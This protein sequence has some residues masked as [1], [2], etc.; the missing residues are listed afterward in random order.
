M[1]TPYTPA[2]ERP[3]CLFPPAARPSFFSYLLPQKCGDLSNQMY[4]VIVNEASP[5]FS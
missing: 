2:K 4:I 5:Y 3:M 1:D